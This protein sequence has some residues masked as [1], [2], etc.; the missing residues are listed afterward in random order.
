MRHNNLGAGWYTLAD[1]FEDAKAHSHVGNGTS[2]VIE[3]RVPDIKEGHAQLNPWLWNAEKAM[4]GQWY[5]L[6]KPLPSSF[7]VNVHPVD[8]GQ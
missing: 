1:N 6:R 7:I 2:V 4:S 5:A 3:F 8:H